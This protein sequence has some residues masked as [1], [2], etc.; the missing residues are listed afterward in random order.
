[1]NQ[2]P[3]TV[4]LP[5]HGSAP[6]WDGS[7]DFQTQALGLVVDHLTGPTDIVGHSF[8]ATVALR[9]AV[10][11]PDLVRSLVLIEPVFFKAAAEI[12]PPKTLEYQKDDAA[13]AEAIAAGNMDK[14]AELFTD[15]WGVQP[16][17]TLGPEMQKS[18]SKRM[19]LVA[20]SAPSIMEDNANVWPR[21]G[22]VDIPAL[23]LDGSKS[24]EIIS[25]IQEGLLSVMPQAERHVIE[26]AAHLLPIT[27][28]KAVAQKI[29]AFQQ[30]Q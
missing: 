25:L 18:I 16:F 23:L 20:A 22:E 17:R 14:A 28:P 4:E 2:S 1:M 19:H 11:R 13:V 7:Q 15:I 8:G 6:E 3:D 5:G 12:N 27:H 26:G 30:R 21:L 29:L 9:L 10:E 24:P